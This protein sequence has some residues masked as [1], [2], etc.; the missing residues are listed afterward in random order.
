MKI[1]S[2]QYSINNNSFEIYLSGCNGNPKCK[3]CHNQELWD[4]HIG[5][6]YDQKI[7][8]ALQK[9]IYKFETLIDNIMILGGEPLD[10]DI[11]DFYFFIQ[12]MKSFNKKL[13]LFTRY[14]INEI[15]PKILKQFDFVKTGKYD[16]SLTTEN[17]IQYN[18]T[19][20]TSNQKIHK[21]GIDY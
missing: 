10:Q 2:T 6:E 12:D 9:K 11:E 3:G 20:P 19:L 7:F 8:G 4:F 5:K 15:E 14:E 1:A 18:I 21:K 16:Y 17:N 13:W